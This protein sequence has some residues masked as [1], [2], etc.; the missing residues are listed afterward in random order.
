[1]LDAARAYAARREIDNT[2]ETGVVARVLEQ[3]QIR[4]RVFDFGAFEKPQTAIHAVR[5]GGVEQSGFNHTALRVAAVKNGDFAAGHHTFCTVTVAPVTQQL[6][7]LFHHPIGLSQI[8]GRLHHPHRLAR[9]LRG[10]Q[11]FTQAGFVV[12][13]QLVG[14]VQNMAVAAVV[15]L[16][17]DLVLHLEL[18]HKVGHVADACAAKRVNALVIVTYRQHRAARAAE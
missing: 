14:C 11:V 3:T 13:D 2:H 5:H 9:T 6:F 15:L 17:L 10:V 12:L 18:A 16:Q 1:M 7:D 8:A 4:Q